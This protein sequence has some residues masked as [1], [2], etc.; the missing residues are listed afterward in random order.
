MGI[1]R[2]IENLENK[3]NRVYTHVL[4]QIQTHFPN[5]KILICKV[6]LIELKEKIYTICKNRNESKGGWYTPQTEYKIN[7]YCIVDNLMYSFIITTSPA[8]K[9]YTMVISDIEQTTLEAD[10]S[11]P[12]Q[13]L[14]TY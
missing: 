7:W 4:E 2:Q 12:S 6:N 1:Y 11:T 14:P 3:A 10:T 5:K 8:L 9:S 13:A